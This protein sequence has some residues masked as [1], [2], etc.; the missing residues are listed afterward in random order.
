MSDNLKVGTL[1]RLEKWHD[2]TEDFALAMI[3][4]ITNNKSESAHD[5]I[6]CYVFHDMRY[7]NFYLIDIVRWLRHK[8]VSIVE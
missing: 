5:V 4:E 3:V 1:L 2:N 6:N 8:Q 7:V